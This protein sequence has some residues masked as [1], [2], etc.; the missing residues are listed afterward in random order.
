MLTTN[1]DSQHR[2]KLTGIFRVTGMQETERRSLASEKMQIEVA[3]DRVGEFESF[4][5]QLTA[6][7]QRL[8]GCDD[9]SPRAVYELTTG[10]YPRYQGGKCAAN[11]RHADR[12]RFHGILQ[13]NG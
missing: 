5:P 9:R 2:W 10:T 6:K 11:A 3:G 12:I 8:F 7:D 4:E 1:W 13:N